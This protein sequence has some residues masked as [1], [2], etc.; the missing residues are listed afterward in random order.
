MTLS[1]LLSLIAPTLSMALLTVGNGLFTTTTT[2][3]LQSMQVST[4]LIG[5]IASSYFAGLVLGSYFTKRLFT[6][7]G[8]IRSFALFAAFIAVATIAQGTSNFIL[9]IPCRFVV[10]YCIAGL[11]IV[12]E[13]WFLKQSTEES[14]GMV[15]G[16][17]LFTYY[18]ALAGGQLL[19]LIHFSSPLLI[20]C[21]ISALAS[22]SIIPVCF[23]RFS[24]PGIESEALF[25][26]G[27]LFQKAHVGIIGCFVAGLV[28]GV[29]FGL[30]PLYLD[31]IGQNKDNIAIILFLTIIAGALFQI[32]I[33]KISDHFDRRLVL[34]IMCLIAFF[35][36]LLLLFFHQLF[37]GIAILSCFLGGLVY[38]IYPLSISHTTDRISPTEVISALSLLTLV[39]GLGCTIGPLVASTLMTSVGNNSFFMYLGVLMIALG[40][41]AYIQTRQKKPVK[42]KDKTKFV[43]S[44]AET[45][46]VIGRADEDDLLKE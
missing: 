25:S 44:K 22:L 14:K 46:S 41:Y 23:T 24:E 35:V 45:P 16:S 5:I 26:P 36:C 37:I 15:F 40:L 1:K 42:D 43:A 32:P 3:Q 2:L 4:W 8:Y 13:S 27:L 38:T 30:Y 17:Y 10:G 12:V 11:F 29:I 9:W 31:H 28:L 34:S 6:R 39:Y 33:G 21:L 18:L 20:F 19:L 7:V